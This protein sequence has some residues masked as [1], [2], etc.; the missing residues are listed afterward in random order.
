MSVPHIVLGLCILAFSCGVA[1][2]SFGTLAYQRQRRRFYRSFTLQFTG[3]TLILLAEGIRTYDLVTAGALWPAVQIVLAVLTTLGNGLLGYALPLFALDLTGVALTARRTIVHGIL[4]AVLAVMGCFMELFPIAPTFI[5]DYLAMIGLYGYGMLILV[6]GLR[7]IEDPALQVLTKRFLFLAGCTALPGV[8]QLVLRFLPDAPNDLR[9]YPLVQLVYYL[10]S[11]GLLLS[12]VLRTP[13]TQP[14]VGGCA[15]SVDFVQRYNISPR[16]CEIITAL[17][18]GVSNR[19]LAETLF[20]SA[21]TVKNHIYHIYQ[22]T[23]AGNK[24]QLINL[25]RTF[26]PMGQPPVNRWGDAEAQISPK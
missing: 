6:R 16:E 26:E 25:I 8:A 7:K 9:Q 24:V 14:F 18:Q 11:I 12:Y 1:V 15:L 20:I 21:Q 17:E 13:R 2:I 3:S 23:G 5:V 4:A 22:K 19:K 10:V